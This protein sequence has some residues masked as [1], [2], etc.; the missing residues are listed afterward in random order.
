[1]LNIPMFRTTIQKLRSFLEFMSQDLTRARYIQHWDLTDMMPF[2]RLSESEINA[3]QTVLAAVLLHAINLNHIIID[4]AD[5]MDPQILQALSQ[6]KKLTDLETWG[7]D[8]EVQQH[9][10]QIQSPV[11]FARIGFIDELDES[12]HSGLMEFNPTF[13]LQQFTATLEN[14]QMDITG[15]NRAFRIVFSQI[16]FPNVRTLGLVL[17][18]SDDPNQTIDVGW[19]FLSDAFPNLVHVE[20]LWNVYR[21]GGIPF[22]PD[23]LDVEMARQDIHS[24]TT[25]RWPRMKT[26]RACTEVCYAGGPTSNVHRW[27]DATVTPDNQHIFHTV[28]DT[29]SPVVLGVMVAVYHFDA[30][31]LLDLLPATRVK[32]LDLGLRFTEVDEAVEP[33][34]DDVDTINAKLR[35]IAI[36][37]RASPLVYLAIQCFGLRHPV[38]VW[39][40]EDGKRIDIHGFLRTLQHPDLKC[41]RLCDFS[42][43]LRRPRHWRFDMDH[44]TGRQSIIL[45]LDMDT[46]EDRTIPGPSH[47]TR[48]GPLLNWDILVMLPQHLDQNDDI[49][50]CMRTCRDLYE[51]CVKALLRE[52]KL[53][54]V[55]GL[56]F[57]HKRLWSFLEFMGRD[58]TRA[59]YIRRLDLS[60]IILDGLS[61]H[62]TQVAVAMLAV[63]LAHAT[64]LDNV[65]LDCS[66]FLDPHCPWFLQALSSLKTLTDLEIWGVDDTVQSY[67][68][69]ME[70]P[71]RTVYIGLIEPDES[72]DDEPIELMQICPTI[73][74]QQFTATLED[75]EL[76]ISG[77]GVTFYMELTQVVFPKV[78]R[79]CMWSDW[80]EHPNQTIDIGWEFLAIS[81]PNLV[82]LE[83]PWEVYL[84]GEILQYEDMMDVEIA[85]QDI[86]SMTPSRWPQMK[87]IKACTEVCYAG[88]PTSNVHRWEDATVTPD[89]KHMFDTVIDILN[90]V[91]LEVTVALNDF[92][93]SELLTLLP[94]TRVKYLFLVLRM[95]VIE[96]AR[97]HLD[98][99]DTINAKLRN[100]AISLQASSLTYLVI[101]MGRWG[102][103]EWSR[104]D[105]DGFLATFQHPTLKCLRLCDFEPR[106]R[107]RHWRMDLDDETGLRGIARPLD[108]KSR[109]DRAYEQSCFEESDYLSWTC[110]INTE[111]ALSLADDARLAF[112]KSRRRKKLILETGIS[113]VEADMQL[114]SAPLGAFN[115]C[116]FYAIIN[117]MNPVVLEA[118]T[119]ANE[120]DANELLD[121]LPAASVKC[122]LNASCMA[123]ND[124]TALQADDVD[125]SLHVS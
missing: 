74:L 116:M 34:L 123:T 97:L 51:P 28:L 35:N 70:S 91:V 63:V 94:A 108:M 84:P 90:P 2:D 24:V 8:E 82:H 112:A 12:D 67:V 105:T 18:A 114:E 109:E 58:F 101:R 1:M 16:V 10:A 73:L 46:K 87:T 122:L 119:A 38:D 79:L 7:V 88:G 78:R 65:T 44:E 27:D 54:R 4:C 30:S 23:L 103:K 39:E 45:P 43:A 111:L 21:D 3:A 42:K 76:K 93:V 83:M 50:A 69:Q 66:K 37:L 25:S 85:R 15:L 106:G 53:R 26:M 86:H 100:I 99:I 89:N 98:D 118:N 121:L 32:Y 107:S 113:F 61:E 117:T 59:R 49:L 29:I 125:Q 95:P 96:T 104:V 31:N 19:E 77:M 80:R 47:M 48:R 33:L 75:V 55:F 40:A 5:F 41:L 64:N 120:I 72:E 36:A 9:L 71:V 11:R 22:Y 56:S 102:C 14:V 6:L 115:K 13:L 110:C 81:F 92:D 68:A 124:G 62:E 20:L 17:D 57:A 52:A 60:Q